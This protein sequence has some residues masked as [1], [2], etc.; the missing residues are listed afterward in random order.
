M[1]R[2]IVF[3]LEKHTWPAKYG[4][5]KDRVKG[6]MRDTRFKEKIEDVCKTYSKGLWQSQPGG[7]FPGDKEVMVL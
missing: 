5:G 2:V 7:S 4:K 6:H 1:W 3:D